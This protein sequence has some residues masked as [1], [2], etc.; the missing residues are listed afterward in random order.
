[1]Q[2]DDSDGALDSWARFCAL[3]GDLVGGAGD[4]SVGPRLAPAVADLCARGLATLVRDYFLHNLE[5]RTSLFSLPPSHPQPLFH[6]RA[7][8]EPGV[9]IA[10]RAWCL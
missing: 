3:T 7:G 8:W 6:R 9:R 1:M 5:V 10:L 2:L 4:L